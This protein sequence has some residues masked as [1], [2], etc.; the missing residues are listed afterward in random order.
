M[1]KFA[2]LIFLFISSAYAKPN[3]VIYTTDSFA[4]DWAVGGKIKQNFEQ[5]YDC[6]I[7]YVVLSDSASLL[8][9]LK[10]EK[11][12]LKADLIIGLDSNDMKQAKDLNFLEYHQLITD[13]SNLPIKWT[14]DYF[15][16]YNY[17]ILSFIFDKTKT[18]PVNSFQ[19]L[20]DSNSSII[21]TDPRSCTTGLNFVN[22]VNAVFGDQSSAIWR[23]LVPKILT[24]TRSWSE[25]YNLF[26]RGEVDFVISYTT[27]PI[28]HIK[29]ENNYNFQATIFTEGNYIQIETAARTI[30]QDNSEL[31]KSFLKYIIS[32]D[33]QQ[34]MFNENYM[35]PV[36]KVDL[37]PIA[38]Y[39]IILNKI[40]YINPETVNQFRRIWITEWLNAF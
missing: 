5:L 9:R 6:N 8:S 34:S 30:K 31:S 10:H 7:E 35:L 25:A 15:I 36:A 23:K 20:I 26:L 11:N 2:F 33:A 14:D 3:L 12:H 37:P 29:N 4:A 27:S 39:A 1:L 28:Y 32:K 19:Q 13:Y 38:N 21:I 24:V 16:A 22:W 18:K 17:G 40:L